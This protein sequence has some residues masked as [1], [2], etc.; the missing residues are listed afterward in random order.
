M[1]LDT[2]RLLELR[3]GLFGRR[4]GSLLKSLILGEPFEREFDLGLGT[5]N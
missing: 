1:L 3:L 2:E 5:D 4:G